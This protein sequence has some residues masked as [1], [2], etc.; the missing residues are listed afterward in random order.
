M[1]ASELIKKIQLA[2]DDCGDRDICLI[3]RKNI[4]EPILCV[5]NS[6]PEDKKFWICNKKQYDVFRSPR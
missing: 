4:S 5:I 6:A 3:N 1:K 2:I